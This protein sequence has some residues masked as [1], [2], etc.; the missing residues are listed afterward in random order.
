MLA[1]VSALI[2]VAQSFEL[3]SFGMWSE[4]ATPEMRAVANLAQPNN[5]ATLL[6]LG[7]LGALY[8]SNSR[9]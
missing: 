9:G 8:L 6:G 2:V 7:A 4:Y 5:L 3:A 1:L